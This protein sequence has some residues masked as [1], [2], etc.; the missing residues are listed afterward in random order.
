MP[1]PGPNAPVPESPSPSFGPRPNTDADLLRLQY[2]KPTSV[3]WLVFTL[4]CVTSWMLYLHR[5]TWNLI[6]PELIK[7]YGW[8]REK[9]GLLYTCFTPAYGGGQIPSG[10][11]CDWLGPHLFLGGIILLWSVALP[12]HGLQTGFSGLAGVRVLFGAAQAGGYPALSKITYSWFPQRSRTGVQGWVA[13]FFGR[14][15][16]AMSSILM[17]TVLMALLGLTWRQSLIMLGLMGVVFAVVFAVVFRNSPDEHPSVNRAERELIN[18]GRT[19]P[20]PGSR[21]GLP[22][23]RALNNRSMV[24]FVIQQMTSAGADMAYVA[25]MGDYFINAKGFDMKT[26]G[27]LISLPLWGGAAGGIFAGYFSDWL[28]P[29]IGSRRWGRVAVGFSGKFIACLLMFLAIQQQSGLM[30]GLVLFFVK[31]FTDW[32]QPTV[33]GACTDIGGR[34][35]ATVFGIINTA[36]SV[37]G[38]ITPWLFGRIVDYSTASRIVEGVEEKIVNYNPMLATVALLYLISALAWFFVDCSK[39]LDQDDEA[40]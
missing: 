29:R 33:W 27:L 30:A 26:A 15:G 10:V 25:F 22:W 39:P 38:L 1:D 35:S 6:T 16:G 34:Y 13:T 36:G 4:A 37:G 8:S 9:V 5:Y 11:L 3:R 12:L 21:R 24:F 20:A 40:D 28:I 23:G 7:E 31:F 19:P 32:S 2:E 14:S 18:E 17:G